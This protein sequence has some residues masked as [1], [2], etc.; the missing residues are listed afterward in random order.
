MLTMENKVA[1]TGG[2][3]LTTVYTMTIYDL[4]MAAAV[5]LIGGFFGILGKDLYYWI[6]NKKW[7]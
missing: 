5:G 6:K 3:L 1:Y 2:F 4:L 7:K